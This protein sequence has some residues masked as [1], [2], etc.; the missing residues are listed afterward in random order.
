[1]IQI[2]QIVFGS[3]YV[4]FLPGLVLSYVF[5]KRGEKDIIERII[6][7]FALSIVVIPLLTFYL[8]FLFMIKINLMNVSLIV[9]SVIAVSL[10]ILLWR[11]RK[12]QK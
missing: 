5:F 10:G 8:N 7:S 1:M 4:L 3:I 9:L 11:A 12:S 6:F 2:F